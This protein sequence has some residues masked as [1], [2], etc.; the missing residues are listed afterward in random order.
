MI[1]LS[2]FEPLIL[3]IS[4]TCM[5]SLLKL[6]SKPI[7][8]QNCRSLRSNMPLECHDSMPVHIM[9]NI[10]IFFNS[11]CGR[12]SCET[13]SPWEAIYNNKSAQNRLCI[14][15]I[16]VKLPPLHNKEATKIYNEVC[17]KSGSWVWY[18]STIDQPPSDVFHDL[19]PSTGNW[20]CWLGRSVPA[21]CEWPFPEHLLAAF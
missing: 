19:L 4:H 11:L 6:D 18:M 21:E 7:S 9:I 10:A 1:P 8:S 13:W 5:R 12:E 14:Q 2:W 16:V 17:Q 15:R 3:D 20:I